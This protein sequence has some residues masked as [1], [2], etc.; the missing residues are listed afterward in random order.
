[1]DLTLLEPQL[2]AVAA[3][4][5]V[6]SAVGAILMAA[7]DL[8]FGRPRLVQD[9]DTLRRFPQ[10]DRTGNPS[11]IAE[12]DRWFA[13]V[14]YFSRLPL[15]TSAALGL[16]VLSGILVGGLSYLLLELTEIAILL[17]V[18]AGAI[19]LIVLSIAHRRCMAKIQEQ[20]PMAID[21]LARA[22]RAG[23][24]VDQAFALLGTASPEPLATEFRRCSRQ[25]EMGLSVTQT[26]EG[27]CD[28]VGLMDV[29]IFATTLSVHRET[30]GRL[31]E[32]LERLSA[33][34]RD[35]MAYYRTLKSVTGA[36]RISVVVITALGPILFAWL[37]LFQ[38]EYGQRLLD[39]PIGRMA[40]AYAA[41]SEAIGLFWV[42]RLFRSTY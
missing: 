39:E 40:L 21:L 3:F 4:A 42:W 27:L 2:V 16:I 9:A 33:V 26:L 36:G 24:S 10:T 31:A 23:E 37:F 12:F 41:V 30:G 25:L 20:F 6:A 19:V 32:T 15:S 34:I 14:V 7:R 11:S 38:P 17:G 1:M 13:R 29:R 18:S 28:R 35:R 5:G 8:I 22:V